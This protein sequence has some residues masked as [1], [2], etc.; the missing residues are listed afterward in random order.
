MCYDCIY[1]SESKEKEKHNRYA[2]YRNKL[3]VFYKYLKGEELPEGV[4]CTIPNLKPNVAFSVIWFLQEIMHVL[5]ENIEQCD[6]CNELFDTEREGI[7]LDDQYLD[8]DTGKT[9][10]KKYWGH[11][12]DGC[13]PNVEF[14]VK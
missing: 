6:G 4:E 9:L 13:V 5:P 1:N 12:C 7:V 11:W 2:D 3:D 14:E 8:S 10:A